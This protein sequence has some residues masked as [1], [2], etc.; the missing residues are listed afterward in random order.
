M[1]IKNLLKKQNNDD[2]KVFVNMNDIHNDVEEDSNNVIIT[3]GE[4]NTSNRQNKQVCVYKLTRS[5]L[6]SSH[7]QQKNT[8]LF[9]FC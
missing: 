5:I 4:A 2:F 1:F 3:D 9:V 6:A 8:N 7:H